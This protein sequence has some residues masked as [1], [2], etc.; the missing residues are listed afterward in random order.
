[1]EFRGR[2]EVSPRKAEYLKYILESGGCV[3]T[4]DI[5]HNFGISPSTATKAIREMAEAGLLF[6]MLYA[7]ATLT[8]KGEHMAQFIQRR[9]RILT[10]LFSHYGFTPGEACA[11][12]KS[13]EH[14]VSREAVNRIC[15]SLGHPMMSV[16]GRIEHEEGCCSESTE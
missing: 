9:H 14:H 6:H 12:V 11:E 3:R 2:D 13:F 1:M 15:A 8:E 5:A 10:L 4:T 7:G 16:C